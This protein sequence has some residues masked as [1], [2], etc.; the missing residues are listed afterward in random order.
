MT[1][2]NEGE[3]PRGAKRDRRVAILDAAAA[4]LLRYG[5]RK[6][7]VDEVARLADISRQG[8]YQHFPTKDA[9]FA[10]TIDHLLETSIASSRAALKA[11]GIPLEERILKAFESMAGETLVSRLDE[12]LETA[13]RLTGRTARELE[14]AIIAEF[15]RALEGTADSSPWRR[16]GDTAESVATVLYATS[17]GLKRIASSVPDYLDKMRRTIRFVCNP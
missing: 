8:L 10:A 12:V 15:A 5:F 4:T 2:M 9:L 16:N 1:S 6:A 11:P 13:E 7:S 3:A 14:G 17:A